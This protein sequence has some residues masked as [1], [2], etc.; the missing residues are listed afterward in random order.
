MI[1]ECADCRSYVDAQPHGSF[2]RLSNGQEASLLISLL[3]CP[4][5]RS[6]IL[7][8]Q[9]NVG[10][11][12]VGDIWDTP[13][14]VYPTAELRVNPNAPKDIR[15]AFDEACS[16]YRAGAFTAS[17]IM[18]RKTLEGICVAHG[19]E[20]RSLANS[21]KRMRDQNS[22][23]DR[24]FEWSNLMR[25]VGNEAAH[26]VGL[27]VRQADAKDIIEF[28]NAIMDYLFSFRDRFEDFKKRRQSVEAKPNGIAS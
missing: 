21:L 1:V 12:A 10:N 15:L 25:T 27:S 26:G 9:T 3:Q 11:M 13:Q 22:I 7:V 2:E 4:Q 8:R 20:E 28:T 14:L 5:C 16:C 19:V 18:C 23:D 6:P 17:A 24:L